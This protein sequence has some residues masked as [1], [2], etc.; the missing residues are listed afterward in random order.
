MH[1]PTRTAFFGSFVFHVWENVYEPAEDSILFAE[2]L[3]VKEGDSVIDMGTGCGILGIVAT[4]K[5][6]R[7]VAIDTNPYAIHC[8][9]ENA[10]RNEVLGKMLFIRG[11]LFSPFRSKEKFDLILF[12]APYLPSHPEEKCDWLVRAWD[13]GVNGRKVVDRF[14]QEA[15]HHLEQNGRILM[16]QSTLSNVN[17]T[18]ARF[19]QRGLE[20]KIIADRALPFFETAVLLESRVLY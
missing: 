1:S 10:R 2:N 8:A 18:M 19:R 7:V 14:I 5:A 15:S 4:T 6:E 3:S 12:N 11:D 13:G 20:T 17:E 16:M 9:R